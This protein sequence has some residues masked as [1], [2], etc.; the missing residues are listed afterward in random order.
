MNTSMT[1]NPTGSRRWKLLTGIVAAGL[2]AGLTGCSTTK[3]AR[4][5]TESGF[6]GDYSQLEKGKSGQAQLIYINPSVDWKKYTKVYIEPV[7]LWKSDDK[8]SALGK[9]SPENQQML[10]NFLYTELHNSLEKNFTIADSAGPDTLVLHCAITQA[11]KSGPVRNLMT[12]IV[13]FGIAA[14]ILKT[15][16]F[17]RGIGVGEVQV[18]AELLD[19]ATNQR[20]MAAVD[21]RCG[22]KALRTKFDGSWGDVKLAF[23]YWADRLDT[24]LTELK[25]GSEDKETL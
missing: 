21:R 5:V 25:A 6:L 12:S 16:A 15:A 13:P 23:D 22:T 24:R 19:G 8:E 2:L 11:D 9:L 10:V 3:Q 1:M 14:N 18:E 4:S 17:G 7:E 20:L